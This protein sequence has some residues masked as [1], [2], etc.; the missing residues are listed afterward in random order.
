MVAYHDLE[1]GVPSHD[2]VHLFELLSLE[3]AQ[4]GLSW[5]TVLAK[6]EGYRAAFAGFE[7]EAVAAFDAGDVERLLADGRIIRNRAKVEAV[8]TNARVV[9]AMHEVGSSLDELLWSA[10]G[11]T[12][13]GSG[14]RTPDEVPV[15]T[16]EA[17]GLTA[18]LRRAGFRFVGPTITYSLMQ[19]A[20]IVND[21][22]V[23]CYRWAELSS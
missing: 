22:L 3:S 19:A 15:T 4:A 12:P 5:S 8:V 14:W 10:V 11:G 7:V 6:R 17:H 13:I 2:E 9:R 23:S 16:P 21:H 1:W 20:G 18:E